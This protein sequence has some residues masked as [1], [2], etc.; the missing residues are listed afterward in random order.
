MAKSSQSRPS[1]IVLSVWWE[2]KGAVVR[3]VIEP[4]PIM[5]KVAGDSSTASEIVE[6]ELEG[7]D[8]CWERVF[9]FST[10]NS[11]RMVRGCRNLRQKGDVSSWS[12]MGGARLLVTFSLSRIRFFSASSC[13]MC[14]SFALVG[15]RYAPDQP[16]QRKYLLLTMPTSL[17]QRT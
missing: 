8:A 1:F 6:G 4:V 15:D 5:Y 10:R 2:E 9:T 13:L 16:S 17:P 11:V 12:D 7:R 3:H 14:A